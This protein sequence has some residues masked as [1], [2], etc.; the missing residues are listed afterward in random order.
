MP[1]METFLFMYP[2]GTTMPDGTTTYPAPFGNTTTLTDDQDT[3][4]DNMTS[5]GNFM[6]WSGP[7]V[8]FGFTSNNEPVIFDGSTSNYFILSH[9]NTQSGNIGFSN[10]GTYGYC[11]AKG[12]LIATPLGNRR[13]ESIST[14]DLVLTDTSVAVPVKWLGVQTV[15]K[16][17]C[18][19]NMQPVR[20]CAGALGNGLPRNDLTVTADHGMV[21]DGL[22]INASALIN[23]A[24]IDWV[25]LDELPDQVTYYHVETENHDVILANGA[26]AE[27]FVDAVTRAKF[28]NY[29]EYLDL[30][31]AERIIPEMERP[32]ISSQRLL[33]QAIRERLDIGLPPKRERISA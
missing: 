14:G 33:P 23:G 15:S 10:S 20:I 21:I 28:D 5:V 12:T 19:P 26:P 25:P 31:G 18:G 29:Q 9:N 30:Y 17:L 3:I 16:L 13:V 27:T 1:A 24:D 6:S 7:V 22:V 2:L 32:R 11:F 4:D 8:L